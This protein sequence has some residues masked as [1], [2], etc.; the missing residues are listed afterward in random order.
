MT[1]KVATLLDLQT[2]KNYVKNANH[3]NVDGVKVPRL[4]QSKS[5]L[6]IIDIP[7]LQENLFI[8]ITLS[9]V[10]DIIKKNHIF[11]NVILVSKPYIIKVFPKSDMAIVWIFEMFKV[12]VKQEG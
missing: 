11:N 9:M 2:I 4:P 1:N 10:K 7:Y 6:K 3:I 5:Y 12:V 8:P